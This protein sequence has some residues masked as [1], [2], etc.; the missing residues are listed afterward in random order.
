[1]LDIFG[2]AHVAAPSELD[3]LSETKDPK[4]LVVELAECKATI[5][6]PRHPSN[7]I[8]AADSVVAL[9]GDVFGKPRGPEDAIKTLSHLRGRV[10]QVVTGVA[11]VNLQLQTIRTSFVTTHVA[12]RDASDAE[13]AAYVATG[14]PLDK[15]GSY[16]IQGLGGALVDG[17][18][19]CYTNVIGLPMCEVVALYG[20]GASTARQSARSS[21]ALDACAKC[22]CPQGCLLLQSQDV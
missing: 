6:A 14:E 12:M 11:L 16:A 10:H 21:G 19:G 3:E 5:V 1:L 18:E 22:R 15:A 9:D 17:I 20:P 8:L 7:Y 13:I 4:R 2:I